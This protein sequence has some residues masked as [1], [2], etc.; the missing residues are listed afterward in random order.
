MIVREIVHAIVLS[1]GVV[2]EIENF[3]MERPLSL[4]LLSWLALMRIAST[5]CWDAESSN[6]KPWQPRRNSQVFQCHMVQIMMFIKQF[7]LFMGS[8]I[9]R[10]NSQYALTFKPGGTYYSHQGCRSPF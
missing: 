1:E 8:C 3:A 7:R 4:A 6:Q 2:R 10:E 5:G 9:L